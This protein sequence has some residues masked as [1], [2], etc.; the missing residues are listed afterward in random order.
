MSRP[1][2]KPTVTAA[3]VGGNKYNVTVMPNTATP[4]KSYPAGGWGFYTIAARSG[5][6]NQ[7]FTC[8]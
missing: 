5:L 4:L 7:G 6:Q 2:S 8:T 1:C 3:N